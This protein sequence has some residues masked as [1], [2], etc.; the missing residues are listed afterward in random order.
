MKSASPLMADELVAC[1][2][3]GIPA[4]P[5]QVSHLAARIWAEAACHRSAFAWG[6][7]PPGAADRTF[8][9]RSAAMALNGG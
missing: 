4:T 7:L 2:A 8:A 1:V 3:S 9:L 5:A 6:D